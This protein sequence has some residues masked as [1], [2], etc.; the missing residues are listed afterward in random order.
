MIT[1]DIIST[2]LAK[3]QDQMGGIDQIALRRIL[4]DTMSSYNVQMK[5]GVGEVSDLPDKIAK[6]LSCR[7]LD[8]LSE[9]TI[10]N[11]KYNLDRFAEFVQKR[12]TTITAQDI[13]EFLSHLVETRNITNST[14][15]TQKSILKAFFGW[16]ETEE[17]ITN[18][19]TKKIRPTKCAKPIKKSLTIE[20]LELLRNACKTPRQRCMLELFFSSGMRLAELHRVNIHDID[21][22]SNSIKIVGKGNKERVVYFSDKARLYIKKY[23]AVRGSFED[24]ALFIASKHPHARM[25]TRSIQQE[26]NAIAENANVESHVHPHK[27]RRTFATFG[28][29]SGMSLTSLRGILGHAKLETTMLYVDADQEAEAYEHSRYINQ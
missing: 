21:W 17:Y 4:E 27:L 20:E 11:Y 9:L 12:V 28:S 3:T 2:I 7:K 19:P 8:G 13:R 22:Q 18:S 26:I 15:E 6:Y 16:L 5:E 25:G 14:L 23:L 24:P 1:E 29:R 10:K